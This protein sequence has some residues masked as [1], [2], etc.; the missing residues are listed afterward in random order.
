MATAREL[1]EQAEALMRSERAARMSGDIPTLTD[2]VPI[3]HDVIVGAAALDMRRAPMSLD[4]IPMLTEAVEDFDT[5][6][7]PLA[8][9]LDDELA[10]WRE[11]NDASIDVAAPAAAPV[12]AEAPALQHETPES[13][14]TFGVVEAR[15]AESPPQAAPVDS[16]PT[17]DE[18][19]PIA[20]DSARWNALAEDIRMQVLQRIDI[21]TDT[22]LK[23]QLNQRLQPIVDRASADLVAAINQHVGQL[24]RAYV[25]EAIEREIEKWRENARTTLPPG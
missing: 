3:P 11:T 13:P 6:S 19:A 4:D 23:D 15:I 9:S 18:A 2:S 10:M 21:F 1:L 20:D 16:P 24:L 5:P 22:G 7:I 17:M 14:E 12:A 8:Q 25:A